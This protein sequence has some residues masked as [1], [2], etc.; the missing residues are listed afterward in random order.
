MSI[1][2]SA[3]TVN[4]KTDVKSN[5]VVNTELNF[6]L[7]KD[8]NLEPATAGVSAQ[9]FRL[10]ADNNL[11]SE[12]KNL[13]NGFTLYDGCDEKT[14]VFYPAGTDLNKLSNDLLLSE[15]LTSID[16]NDGEVIGEMGD[17]ILPQYDVNTETWSFFIYQVTLDYNDKAL[18]KI[19]D[20]SETY[21]GELL[22]NYPVP[23]EISVEY[24]LMYQKTVGCGINMHEI[25]KSEQ[26]RVFSLWGLNGLTGLWEEIDTNIDTNPVKPFKPYATVSME[27][28]ENSSDKKSI[29]CMGVQDL[30]ITLF[31]PK[32][33]CPDPENNIDKDQLNGYVFYC[34][35][36]LC[37]N[38]CYGIDPCKIRNGCDNFCVKL[39]ETSV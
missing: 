23:S 35:T 39:Y 19:Y 12:D 16:G 14:Y 28:K 25:L 13:K 9:I 29:T 8:F 10:P 33:S 1:G 30:K 24:T 37:F 4:V 38:N 22:Y 21:S 5:G 20:K 17:A 27:E 32:L 3:P 6:C 26:G 2:G 36:M 18:T 34:D 7:N 15:N 31:N 11:P